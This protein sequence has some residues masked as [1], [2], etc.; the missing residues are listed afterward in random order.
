MFCQRGKLIT[1]LALEQPTKEWKVLETVKDST[2]VECATKSVD[3]ASQCIIN[4]EATFIDKNNI[5][6]EIGLNMVDDI[7]GCDHASPSFYELQPMRKTTNVIGNA[8]DEVDSSMDNDIT[9]EI[10][11]GQRC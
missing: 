9:P 3:N 4:G 7:P 8:T 2:V 5:A 6:C 1:K 11:Y 10:E